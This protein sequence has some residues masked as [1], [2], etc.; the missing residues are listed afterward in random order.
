MAKAIIDCSL[1]GRIGECYI[2]SGRYYLVKE[3]FDTL[4]EV[5]GKRK[6]QTYLSTELVSKMAPIAEKIFLKL[7]LKPSV[8]PYSVY[9]LNTNANFSAKKAKDELGLRIRPI[10]NT[11]TDTARWIKKIYN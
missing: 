3:L 11:L 7:H 8:T 5:S 4:S 2:L 10:E 9:T 6:I 1:I